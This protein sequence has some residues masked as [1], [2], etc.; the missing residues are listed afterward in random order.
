MDVRHPFIH[1]PPSLSSSVLL[2]P[3]F[4]KFDAEITLLLMLSA[5]AELAAP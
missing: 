1:F 2:V 3:L 4:E 5:S